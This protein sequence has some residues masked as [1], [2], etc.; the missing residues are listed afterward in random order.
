M[1]W[2]PIW[3]IRDAATENRIEG[4]VLLLL[5]LALAAV[6][7]TLHLPK[8]WAFGVLLAAI[9]CWLVVGVVGSGIGC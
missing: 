2:G 7:G 3:F 8:W 1:G 6:F 9:A 4:I 5:G